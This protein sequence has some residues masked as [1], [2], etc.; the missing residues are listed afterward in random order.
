MFLVLYLKTSQNLW[1]H[2]FALIFS[3]RSFIVLQL[4]FRSIVNFE[5]IFLKMWSLCL[6]FFFFFANGC[7]DAPASFAEKTIHY[8]MNRRSHLSKISWVYIWVSVFGLF[9]SISFCIFFL[10]LWQ[11]SQVNDKEKWQELELSVLI[12]SSLFFPSA[13]SHLMLLLSSKIFSDWVIFMFRYPVWCF[14]FC[15]FSILPL[16]CKYYFFTFFS[17]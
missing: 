4:T 1:S 2:R 9:Y 11:R 6:E 7:P 5:W 10:V 12:L 17:I 8:P 13:F 3:S 14:W 16:L 15:F